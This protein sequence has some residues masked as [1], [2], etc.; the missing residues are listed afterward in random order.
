MAWSLISE[1][2]MYKIRYRKDE[3]E[4]FTLKA[5]RT[6]SRFCTVPSKLS[7]EAEI[8]TRDNVMIDEA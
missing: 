4:S 7:F 1:T 5:S 8:R 2:Q 6:S 3:K